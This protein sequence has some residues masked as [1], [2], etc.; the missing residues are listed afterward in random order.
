MIVGDERL[1]KLLC[2]YI[3]PE[4]TQPEL[5][6]IDGGDN[7]VGE[8][9]LCDDI[10]RQRTPEFGPPLHSPTLYCGIRKSTSLES[11]PHVMVFKSTT[12]PLPPVLTGDIETRTEGEASAISQDRSSDKLTEPDALSID[13]K[14]RLMCRGHNSDGLRMY[15]FDLWP[16]HDPRS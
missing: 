14:T 7:D 15:R 12:P 1:Q 10:R 4:R 8:H 11:I 9:G 16:T 2:T 3:W 5:L 6:N 13:L